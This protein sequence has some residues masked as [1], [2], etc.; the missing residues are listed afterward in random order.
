[1]I[2]F[3]SVQCKKDASPIYDTGFLVLLST[4]MKAAMSYT[5]SKIIV[6]QA[7]RQI[8]TKCIWT[9]GQVNVQVLAIIHIWNATLLFPFCSVPK[10]FI[11]NVSYHLINLIQ[12]SK[13]LVSN[14]CSRRVVCRQHQV[15]SSA[16]KKSRPKIASLRHISSA[17][18]QSKLQILTAN[19]VDLI[20]TLAEIGWGL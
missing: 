13:F 20:F 3:P 14:A 19:T 4:E 5:Q 10:R 15:A 1:M 12:M 18:P 7:F 9:W 17:E 2:W 16:N 8:R 6:I 11:C